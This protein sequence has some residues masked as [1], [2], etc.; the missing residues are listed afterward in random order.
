MT[1]RPLILSIVAAA[2][3]LLWPGTAK[4]EFLTSVSFDRQLV[5]PTGLNLG[6]HFAGTSLPQSGTT[7]MSLPS[8]TA[9]TAI[10]NFFAPTEINN[11]AAFRIDTSYSVF[12]NEL[13][14]ER[15]AELNGVAIVFTTLS[16]VHFEF[17]YSNQAVGNAAIVAA[18]VNFNGPGVAINFDGAPYIDSGTNPGVNIPLTSGLLAANATYS[19]KVLMEAAG[20]SSGSIITGQSL[21]DFVLTPVPE[22]STSVLLALGGLA[23]LIYGIR[24]RLQRS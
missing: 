22:P 11:Q 10:Y 24:A 7:S 5:A 12:G 13:V 16:P 8:G 6:P 20:Q 1:R 15:G 17:A 21:F 23:I 14:S 2:S 19:L 18:M 9:I 3:I 4:A